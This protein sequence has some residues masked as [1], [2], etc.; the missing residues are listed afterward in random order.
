MTEGA[1]PRAGGMREVARAAGVSVSTVAN[2]LSRP[3]IVAPGTRQ[4]VEQA[5][6]H[7]GYVPSGP[8][9][10]LRGLPSPLVGSVTLDLANPFFAELNRGIEDRLA[11]AGCLV[12]AGSTDLRPD[13]EQQL[14]D[15][16]RQQAVR[17]IV[18]APIRPDLTILLKLRQAGTPVVLV[19]HP[20][21]DTDLCSVAVDDVLGG[22]LAA[23]HLI[24]LGHRRIAYLGGVVESGTVTRRREGARQAMIAAGLDPD[25]ALIDLRMPIHPPPLID[26]AMLAVQRLLTADPPPTAVLCLNDTAAIGVL[27]GL[28]AAGV[29]V[30]RDISVVGYDDLRFAALLAPPLTTVSQPAYRLG[31]T[32]ADLLLAEKEPDHAHR[33]I[34]FQPT[35]VVRSSTAPP[36]VVS[37][38]PRPGSA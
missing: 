18:V 38:A 10:Q 19:E 35:L 33:E 25:A 5:I 6:Q 4:R 20:R 36:S 9:R 12:L 29:R 30:P 27:Q 37:R 11:E 31:W 8:A 17:G 13:R 22:R 15:L 16:L 2:V 26:A 21:G 24:A 28:A 23:E 3:G 14:L 32:A 7:V 34:M 1:G